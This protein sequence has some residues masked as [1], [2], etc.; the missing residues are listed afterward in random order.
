M[1]GSASDATHRCGIDRTAADTVF[2]YILEKMSVE[3]ARTVTRNPPVG[4]GVVSMEID[5]FDK[6]IYHPIEQI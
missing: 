6:R 1:A 4:G 2:I 5:V 3:F